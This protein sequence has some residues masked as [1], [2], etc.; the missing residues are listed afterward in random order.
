[1]KHS[2][3]T[4]TF[5]LVFLAIFLFTNCEKEPIENGNNV[6]NNNNGGGGNGGGSSTPV[7]PT[8]N[9][10]FS[11]ESGIIADQT[12]VQFS[13]SSTGTISNYIWHF[14][15]NESTA[16]S[17]SPSY[18]FNREGWKTITLHVSGSAGSDAK[19]IQQVRVHAMDPNLYHYSYF[20][21]QNEG[22]IQALR[23]LGLKIGKLKVRN[24]YNNVDLKI[25]L[26]HP[27]SWLAGVYTP[28]ADSYW[29]V[30]ATKTSNIWFDNAPINIG[31]DWG[32]QFEASN[33]SKSAIRSIHYISTY[34]NG[35]FL[36]TAS[37]LYEGG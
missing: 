22:H 12:S 20:S 13:N 32:I 5:C 9:F 28:F 3:I 33:G 29:S 31:D 11:P 18:V 8:A 26:Y 27:D 25:R 35:E 6:D 15:A 34:Q 7:A 17:S 14:G 37:E 23:D 2:S 24:N 19:V 4:S 21:T 1:M 16:Y 10:S 36:V 30:G